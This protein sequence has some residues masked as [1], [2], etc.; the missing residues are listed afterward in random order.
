MPEQQP[1]RQSDFPVQLICSSFSSLHYQCELTV[2]GQAGIIVEARDLERPERDL[3]F[4]QINR[5]RHSLRF[6]NRCYHA[7][8]ARDLARSRIDRAQVHGL[9]E[10][11]IVWIK[12]F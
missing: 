4:R 3:T 6:E 2:I 12:Q 8:H 1:Q 11:E 10:A 7:P 5:G 9:A